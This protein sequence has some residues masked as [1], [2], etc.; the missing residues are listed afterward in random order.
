[1]ASQTPTVLHVAEG[2][3]ASVASRQRELIPVEEGLDRVEPRRGLVDVGH[4]CRVVKHD[5]PCPGQSLGGV[6]RVGRREPSIRSSVEQ[7]RGDLG[8]A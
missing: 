2:L 7:E 8:L 6:E 1:L 3:S 5:C 4:V